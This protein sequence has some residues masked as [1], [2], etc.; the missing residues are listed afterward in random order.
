MRF[1]HG[2]TRLLRA[3]E[4]PTTTATGSTP[5]ARRLRRRTATRL[6]TCPRSCLRRHLA[7][8]LHDACSEG[9]FLA[10]KQA[11]TVAVGFLNWLAARSIAFTIVSRRCDRFFPGGRPRRLCPIPDLGSQKLSAG[12]VRDR[13]SSTRHHPGKKPST[14]SSC[15]ST[16]VSQRGV[17]AEDRLM[18]ALI[19]VFGQPSTKSLPCSG[20]TSPS[21]TVLRPSP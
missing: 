7:H 17:T 8:K 14:N 13:T 9:R 2:D 12:E 16:S 4:Q 10:S 6:P 18:A 20:K 15:S 3:D 1:L 11:V 5:V 21:T 19:L